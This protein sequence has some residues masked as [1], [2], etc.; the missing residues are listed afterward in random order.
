MTTG[1]HRFTID[2]TWL[3]HLLRGALERLREESP[4]D[5]DLARW[6]KE[7]IPQKSIAER[8]GVT[9]DAAEHRIRRLR[10]RLARLLRSHLSRYSSSDAE[11]ALELRFLSRYLPRSS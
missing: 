9:L 10:E 4:G 2:R 6:L 8:L 11:I 5:C 1:E 3:D 7:G